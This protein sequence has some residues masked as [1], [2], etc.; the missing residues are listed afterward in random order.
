MNVA[1]TVFWN[2]Y[3]QGLKGFKLYI[4]NYLEHL[5][6]KEDKDYSEYIENVQH[7]LDTT[8]K[9]MIESLEQKRKEDQDES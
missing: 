9:R 2:G 6:N 7:L 4:E 1:E 8:E 3:E 5:S